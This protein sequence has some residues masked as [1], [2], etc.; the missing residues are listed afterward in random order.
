MFSTNSRRSN[1][2]LSVLACSLVAA[3]LPGCGHATAELEMARQNQA[4]AAKRLEECE[5]QLAEARKSW[6]ASRQGSAEAR[7]VADRFL[8]D[9]SAGDWR[10]AYQRGTKELQQQKS[11]EANVRRYFSPPS[12]PAS[13]VF[14]SHETAIEKDRA[15][16]R[17]IVKDRAQLHEPFTLHLVRQDGGWRVSFFNIGIGEDSADG[18][19]AATTP[20]KAARMTADLFLEAVNSRN[21][22]AADAV[23]SK[24]FQENKGGNKA[25][26]T[27]SKGRFRGETSGYK[28]APLTSFEAVPGHDEFIGRGKLQYRGVLKPDS[29]YTV[30]VVKEGDKWRIASF[31]AEER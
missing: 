23:G 5:A 6:E 25:M 15:A 11:L 16:L 14:F 13:F 7:L 3:S 8:A 26:E 9:V 22:D 20:W 1:H 21:A 18:D 2:V 12:A 31:T 29:K 27:F 30:R 28:C 4:E 17:G 19:G 24:A 10:A